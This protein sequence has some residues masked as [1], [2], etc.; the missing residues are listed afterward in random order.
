MQQQLFGVG[1]YLLVNSSVQQ[2]QPAGDSHQHVEVHRR[3]WH[4]GVVLGDGK[5]VDPGGSW[6]LAQGYLGN[7]LPE[8]PFR[9]LPDDLVAISCMQP[10]EQHELECPLSG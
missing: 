9:A 10:T 5:V 6:E 7:L 3:L 4:N 8:M 2:Q 1:S